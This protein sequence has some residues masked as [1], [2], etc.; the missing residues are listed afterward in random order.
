MKSCEMEIIDTIKTKSHLEIEILPC[1]FCGAG[2]GI[3]ME[4]ENAKGY[5]FCSI[6]HA[7]GPLGYAPRNV[8]DMWN[9]RERPADDP[10]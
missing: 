9:K 5:V 8:V 2:T 3:K 6:C 4:F 1:P 7:A 10:S